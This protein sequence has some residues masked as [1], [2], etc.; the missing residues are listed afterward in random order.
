[1]PQ[2]ESACKGLK[3]SVSKR[4]ADDAQ[5]ARE[6]VAARA[7]RESLF[8]AI[9][10]RVALVFEVA[11]FVTPADGQS[12]QGPRNVG[13]QRL[14]GGGTTTQEEEVE[15]VEFVPS[16]GGKKPVTGARAVAVAALDQVRE[17]AKAKLR[18]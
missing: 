8:V 13:T 9:E 7:V 4:L 11:T 15:D 14:T 2:S 1:M 12:V 6:N 16:A 18:R 10:D 5:I 17:D 3:K